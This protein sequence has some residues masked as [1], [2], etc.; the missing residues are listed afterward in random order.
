MVQLM[1]LMQVHRS[2]VR[3]SYPHPVL[4]RCTAYSIY[5]LVACESLRA[6][7]K[8]IPRS[9]HPPRDPLHFEVKHQRKYNMHVEPRLSPSLARSPAWVIRRSPRLSGE[10]ERRRRRPR[11][12][13]RHSYDA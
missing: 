5:L 11:E 7:S 13:H 3:V 12:P 8:S 2:V 1:Q 6:T 4:Q 9:T 10:G